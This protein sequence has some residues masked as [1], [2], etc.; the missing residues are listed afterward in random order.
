MCCKK[1]YQGEVHSY[2]YDTFITSNDR[3][4]FYATVVML[5]GGFIA[6]HS[7]V[8]V[9][10]IT[11]FTPWS[12]LLFVPS[13]YLFLLT[14]TNLM[15]TS[16]IDPGILPRSKEKEKEWI[17]SGGSSSEERTKEEE[18]SAV[19]ASS[20]TTPLLPSP[21]RSPSSPHR[22]KRMYKKKNKP[23][24]T[25]QV[26]G[27]SVV[28]KFCETCQLFRPPRAV[29]CRFCDNCIERFDHHCP[30]VGNCVGKRNYRYFWGFVTGT[31]V[32][33]LYGFGLCC[34]QITLAMLNTDKSESFLNRLF[35][36]LLTFPTIASVVIGVFCFI[37]FWSVFGLGFYHSYL[38]SVALTTNEEI[39]E[40]YEE[41]DNPFDKGL[42]KNWAHTLCPPQYPTYFSNQS[43]FSFCP[44]PQPDS[45]V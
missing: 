4:G 43:P 19:D 12:V 27:V 14:F 34:I 30:W 21:S 3:A 38:I 1:R 45:F 15:F 11:D 31:A 24:R 8:G 16:L 13:T 39:K 35:D 22:K 33:I 42:C 28:S 10:Y 25:L 2:C 37:M 20:S 44:S 18:T 5:V 26:N 9:W 23:T 17:S 41:E 29:H 36:C 40:A 6:F 32:L 7:T